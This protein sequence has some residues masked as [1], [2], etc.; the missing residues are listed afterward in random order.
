MASIREISRGISL[1]MEF[2]HQLASLKHRLKKLNIDFSRKEYKG[3]LLSLSALNT[4]ACPF[5][6]S[7]SKDP[8]L[9]SELRPFFKAFINNDSESLTDLTTDVLSV[10]FD[11]KVNSRIQN[12][13][14]Q[15]CQK[16]TETL[17]NPK[18]KK[19]QFI[20]PGENIHVGENGSLFISRIR[21]KDAQKED[22]ATVKDIVYVN[23]DDNKT[24]IDVSQPEFSPQ[25]PTSIFSANLSLPED[26]SGDF[27][28]SVAIEGSPKIICLTGLPT[29]KSGLT[30]FSVFKGSKDNLNLSRYGV[31][32]GK[33]IILVVLNKNQFNEGYRYTDKILPTGWL[34][35]TDSQ[36]SDYHKNERVTRLLANSPKHTQEPSDVIKGRISLVNS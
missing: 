35:L 24:L 13:A 16:W 29:E 5:L 14:Q 25:D 19:D 11:K 8:N 6:V 36:L 34:K 10:V 12:N 17:G 31:F 28:Q 33:D 32:I 1:R 23:Y 21:A 30:I 3:S 15:I 9:K 27:F 26:L 18:I 22:G 2:N 7:L 4:I 20:K